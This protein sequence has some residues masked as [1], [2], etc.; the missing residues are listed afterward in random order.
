MPLRALRL[1]PS[2]AETRTSS[3]SFASTLQI[4]AG[5][6][7]TRRVMVHAPVKTTRKYG[8]RAAAQCQNAGSSAECKSKR[9]STYSFSLFFLQG[10][11]YSW[12]CLVYQ[13]ISRR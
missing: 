4:A 7:W 9:R 5:K 8:T 11:M 10:G 12:N 2:M 1:L 13:L 3:Y 6:A